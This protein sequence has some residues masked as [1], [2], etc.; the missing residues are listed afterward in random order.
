MIPGMGKAS[1][2]KR[3]TGHREEMAARS[4]RRDVRRRS[5]IEQRAMRAK[6]CTLAPCALAAELRVRAADLECEEVLAENGRRGIEE[7]RWDAKLLE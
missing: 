6:A 5:S 2:T 1:R 3:T 4:V 7:L